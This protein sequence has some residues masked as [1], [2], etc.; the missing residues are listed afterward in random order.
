MEDNLESGFCWIYQDDLVGRRNT[1]TIT[2]VN[3]DEK[4]R[5]VPWGRDDMG[6]GYGNLNK[7]NLKNVK[8]Y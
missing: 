6:M 2:M 7:I 4:D 8:K 3:I 5:I 1:N